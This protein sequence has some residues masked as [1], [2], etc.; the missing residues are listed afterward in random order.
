MKCVVAGLVTLLTL[1]LLPA[2]AQEASSD[3]ETSD[4]SFNVR[5]YPLALW[6]PTAGW[7]FGGGFVVNDLFEEDTQILLTAVPAVHESVFTASITTADPYEA[8]LYG[9]VNARYETTDRQWYYGI[10]PGASDATQLALDMESFDARIRLGG[11][12]SDRSLFVQPYLGVAHRTVSSFRSEDEGAFEALS[13]ASRLSLLSAAGDASVGTDNQQT[14][15]VVGFDVGF[16]TRDRNYLATRGVLV[17]ASAKRYSELGDFDLA[18][19]QY[20][21]EAY[22]FVP[23]GRSHAIALRAQSA[24]TDNQGDVPVPFYFLHRLDG[25]TVPGLLR[26]RFYGNDLLVL[27][28]GYRFP[29]FEPGGLLD[30]SG[31]ITAHAA[32]VYDDFFD[33]FEAAIS[34]DEDLDPMRDTYPLRPAVSA[35]LHLVPLF[36]DESYLDVGIGLSPEGITAV[37]V[38]FTHHLRNIRPPHQHSGSRW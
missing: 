35:S 29:L 8:P 27:S 26:E 36:R 24:F 9:I 25:R 33:Q 31:Q 30:L 12:L 17:Q 13:A 5:V 21:V 4:P 37:R 20:R 3:E 23:L 16:D 19:A 34:F 38:S 18:F 10:G 14:G 1:G 2:H 32:S 22:G 15:I 28:A 11:Y 6:G 7:G